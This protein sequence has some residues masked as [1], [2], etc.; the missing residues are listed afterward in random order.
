MPTDVVTDAGSEAGYRM[1]VDH[2]GDIIARIDMDGVRR[3]V[4]PEC[5]AIFGYE[6][7]E[8]VG[9]TPLSQVHPDDRARV[10]EGVRSFIVADGAG[11]LRFRQ[12]HR[13]GHY[14]WMET[15]YHLVREPETNEPVEF[16]AVARDISHH[17]AIELDAAEAEARL[18]EHVRLLQM[19]EQAVQLG[20]WRLDARDRKVIWSDE[21]FRIHGMDPAGPLDLA[22]A[23]AAYHPDDRKLVEVAVEEALSHGTPFAFRARLV[24]RDGVIAHVASQGQTTRAPDGT[25]LDIFGT[26][27][28]IS[29][30]VAT[31]ARLSSALEEAKIAERAKADFLATMSHEIRTP[32]TGVMGMIELLRTEQS[33]EVREKLFASLDRSTRT[34]MRV[35][36]DVLDYSHLQSDE[37]TI[38]AT[39]ID[40]G[41]LAEASIDLFRHA[42][43]AKGLE[44]KL[45]FPGSS[46]RVM[47]DGARLQQILFNLLGN[48]IKFTA[49]GSVTLRFTAPTTASDWLIDVRDTGVGMPD[50][51]DV[52]LFRPFVQGDPTIAR[53]FGGT[54]LGLAISRKLAE[55]MGGSLQAMRVDGPGAWLR[56]TLPL[57][58]ADVAVGEARQPVNDAPVP[59]RG[60]LVAEDH[61]ANRLLLD[62]WLSHFGHRVTCVENGRDAVTATAS[63]DFDV[64]L[65]D[66]QMPEMDGFAA[67]M[68]IRNLPGA[69][70]LTPIIL[71]S[72]DVLSQMADEMHAAGVF[73]RMAK[74]VDFAALSERLASLPV[75]G[76]L[77]AEVVDSTRL[78]LML[79]QLGSAEAGRFLELVEAELATAPDQVVG[80][81][82]DG[83]FVAAGRL[84]H[85]S[86]GALDNVGATALVA[87]LRRVRPDMARTEVDSARVAIISA[88]AATRQ[89][90][91]ALLSK[92]R[93]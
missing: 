69:A 35:L 88:A 26:F 72:A 82:R 60:V 16:I 49:T 12:R 56:L 23:L 92:H 10:T 38:R 29:Q 70:A 53:R 15:T 5:R 71:L 80:A 59:V 3:Y 4:S 27:Q 91:A 19:A 48:A 34:L 77:P 85:R 37:F 9:V 1:M 13:D 43:S 67:S 18:H 21:V 46:V 51:A 54:G 17:R 41:A 78:S 62:T 22:A 47:G 30:H 57:V 39:A 50:Q 93:G 63:G 32:M 20:H 55:A 68:A 58:N 11:V 7:E 8:M 66:R 84:A 14:V 33:A 89:Q 2:A 31:E 52:L 44:L 45:E 90:F 6:P 87:A 65:M 83:D 24:R 81:L 42:A 61:P 28:D 25:I 76:S 73:E 79:D 75:R 64:V 36:D 86:I 74:P 40:L